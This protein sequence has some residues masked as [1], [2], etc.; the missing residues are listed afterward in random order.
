[1]YRKFK[2]IFAIIGGFAGG[3][4]ML[5][6]GT[7]EF[8]HSKQL[9]A[10]GQSTQGQVF[11]L[12]DKASYNNR[13][14]TY[15]VWVK[16]HAGDQALLE[17]RAKVSKEFF[18]GT[19]VGDSIPV[20]YLAENP[21]ICQVG[22]GVEL[23]YGYILFGFVFLLGAAYLVLNFDR[24]MD[25]A[26][27]ADNI[28]ESV[29][30]LSLQAFEY[31]SVKADSFK[32]V[33]QAYYNSTQLNL[34]S[35]GFFFIDDQ[36]N[37]TL[38]RRS[39]IH[40]F[41]RHLLGADKTTMASIYHFV[42]KFTQRAL[43]AKS[44]KVLDLETWFTDGSFVCT[45]N[46]EMAGKLDSAPELHALHMPAA[47]SWLTLLDVHLSRVNKHLAAHLGIEAIL[48]NGLADIRNA[49][50]EM[51]RIKSE[52]RTR[53]GLSKAEME[54]L[55]GGSSKAIDNLHEAIVERRARN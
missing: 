44:A 38:R 42:P 4:F 19:R 26:E 23:Q 25:Q 31:R 11:N 49:Q 47:T 34:E 52:F 21:A 37:V 7:T 33:D 1:M 18:E 39:G 13:S 54:R 32:N 12:E 9:A 50:A 2:K 10:H 24:P 20:H 22:Q 6:F 45:S 48:L 17:E 53:T 14:H 55:G 41:I 28:N 35:R 36:E 8:I 46:A 16:F 3:V 29:K 5:I 27:A 43:G 15:Y 30:T 40:T 51:Q